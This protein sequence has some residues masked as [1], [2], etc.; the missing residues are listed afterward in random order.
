MNKFSVLNRKFCKHSKIFL[1]Y[2]KLLI[3]YIYRLQMK[4]KIRLNFKSIFKNYLTKRKYYVKNFIFSKL[5]NN[6][7]NN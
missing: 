4:S 6:Y 5:N 3:K 1:I 7:K 2:H